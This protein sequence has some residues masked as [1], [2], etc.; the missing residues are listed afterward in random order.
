[1]ITDEIVR[2]LETIRD[3]DVV[4]VEWITERAG[5]RGMPFRVKLDR[6]GRAMI[7]GIRL[8][9]IVPMINSLQ[10]R[11][12]ERRSLLQ[13]RFLSKYKMASETDVNDYLDYDLFGEGYASPPGVILMEQLSPQDALRVKA[14]CD[15]ESWWTKMTHDDVR[16]VIWFLIEGWR[17]ACAHAEQSSES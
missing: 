2:N 10:N 4:F 5:K 3:G 12:E 16:R 11:T 17:V 9:H 14:L 15:I 13:M 7:G 1:M 6:K 8:D